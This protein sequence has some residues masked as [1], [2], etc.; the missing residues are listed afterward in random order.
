MQ[1]RLGQS[2]KGGL[3]VEVRVILGSASS[4]A[5]TIGRLIEIELFEDARRLSLVVVVAP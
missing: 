5:G 4:G 2:A 3:L 1:L